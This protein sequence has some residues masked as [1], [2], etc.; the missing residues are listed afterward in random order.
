[1]A[2]ESHAVNNSEVRRAL[3]KE[4]C[5]V[6]A[7]T[8]I[9]PGQAS[10]ASSLSTATS[11]NTPL[12]SS[13]SEFGPWSSLDRS[14]KPLRDEDSLSAEFES[15]QAQRRKTRDTSS[16]T[17]TSIEPIDQPTITTGSKVDHHLEIEQDSLS[18]DNASESLS[19]VDGGGPPQQQQA[20]PI[21]PSIMPL[22]ESQLIM[23]GIAHPFPTD[24]TT[25][26]P[27]FPSIA[28]QH[29]SS[30]HSL[31]AI[32]FPSLNNTLN[33]SPSKSVSGLRR[34][35]PS[36]SPSSCSNSEVSRYYRGIGST[37]VT[38]PSFTSLASHSLRR[39]S[40][41]S[42]KVGPPPKSNPLPQAYT[43]PSSLTPF[44]SNFPGTPSLRIPPATPS[45]HFP[46]PTTPFS[47]SPP[48]LP[49][50]DLHP[51]TY[52]PYLTP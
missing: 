42:K 5:F 15:P 1:M 49:P 17:S 47:A 12:S 27:S 37:K 44:P 9:D 51:S 41:S 32:N 38:R 30:S 10:T 48:S 8:V 26:V 45:L 20:N 31:P 34:F 40:T 39:R 46:P 16:S 43:L 2:F 3:L 13:S 23:L 52:P 50:P 33:S 4:Q 14:S 35:V 19:V 21:I 11:S 7:T 24:R 36:H 6:P 28:S 25:S 29:L 18:D 22:S